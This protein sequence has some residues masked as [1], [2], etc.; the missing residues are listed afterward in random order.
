M[1]DSDQTKS[2]LDEINRLSLTDDGDV[3]K[4]ARYLYEHDIVSG[5]FCPLSPSDARKFRGFIRGDKPSREQKVE[6]HIHSRND[7][8]T[9]RTVLKQELKDFRELSQKKSSLLSHLRQKYRDEMRAETQEDRVEK[10]RVAKLERKQ[11]QAKWEALEQEKR[12][13]KQRLFEEKRDLAAQ[14]KREEEELL[15]LRQQQAIAEEQAEEEHRRELEKIEKQQADR[16]AQQQ[17]QQRREG[18]EAAERERVREFEL[19]KLRLQLEI[20][21]SKKESFDQFSKAAE[22][23]NV[24]VG[25]FMRGMEG[26]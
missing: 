7:V 18:V 21:G 13:E 11:R 26:L 4:L 3:E 20:A 16:I 25:E 19:E 8:V 6:L 17:E 14:K 1:K 9:R 12:A 22:E 23:L 5:G 24:D 15:E 10:E 2:E